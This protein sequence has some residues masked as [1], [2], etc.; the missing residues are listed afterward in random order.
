MRFHPKS[1]G[2]FAVGRLPGRQRRRAALGIDA[3]AGFTLIEMAVA[4]FVIALLLGSIL[5]PLTTQVEQRQ[6]SDTQKTMDEIRD[7]LLGFAAARG[8]LPCPDT[9]GDGVADPAASPAAPAAPAV[10]TNYE[11]WVPWVTL[12]VA[13]GDAWDNR[14]RYRVSPEFTNTPA[15][16]PCAAD[17]RIGLCDTGNI[18]VNTRTGAKVLQALTTNAAVV[19]ASHGRNGLGATS[20]GG[21]ARPAPPAANVDEL[22]NATAAGATFVSRPVVGVSTGCSDTA[23][24]T[25]FCEFDDI[26]TWISAFTIFNRMVAAGKLP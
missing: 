6:I 15:A 7:A 12:S 18:T 21:I 19:I 20:T 3:P 22:T 2:A 23:G 9:T 4:V 5:V 26:V 17:T 1:T 25:A 24:A 14:F 8:Y 13:R 11:G 16:G 10:C